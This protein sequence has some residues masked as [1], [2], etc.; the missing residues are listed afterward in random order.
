MADF[1]ECENCIFIGEYVQNWWAQ[2]GQQ[3]RTRVVLHAPKFDE[4]FGTRMMRTASLAL[5][6]QA[7]PRHQ[8][9][10]SMRATRTR[11]RTETRRGTALDTPGG[12]RR[13]VQ[14]QLQQIVIY[15]RQPWGQVAQIKAVPV[16]Y[17]LSLAWPRL[18]ALAWLAGLKYCCR[19]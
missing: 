18:I 6:R 2:E 13:I 5:R 3:I 8:Q 4:Q 1:S 9:M 15:T 12:P 19:L 17:P 16:R 11:A 10:D 14:V 7:V